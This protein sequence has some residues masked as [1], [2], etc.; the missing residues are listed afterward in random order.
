MSAP[1]FSA[2]KADY[3][4]HWQSA[5]ILPNRLPSITAGAKRVLAGKARYQAVARLMGKDFPWALVGCLHLREANCNFNCH[6]HNGDP[7]S[8]R[9]VH[10][11]AGRPLTGSPPFSWE[12]SALDALTMRG[13]NRVTDWSVE[14]FAYEAEGYN[15][16]GYHGKGLESPY[17]WSGIDDPDK[18]GQ[19]ELAHGKYIRDHVFD[20]SVIDQ[21]PGVMSVLKVLMGLDPTIALGA[22]KAPQTPS[23][24]PSET[25]PVRLNTPPATSV[26]PTSIWAKIGDLMSAAVKAVSPK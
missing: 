19:Q 1:E 10:V 18:A 14:R 13:L 3:T 11:P 26:P 7:L 2:V 6:L 5:E 8:A 15:G 24:K 17:D 22:Q 12:A 23:A 9:T 21:Q 20:A 25:S 16:W 4:R